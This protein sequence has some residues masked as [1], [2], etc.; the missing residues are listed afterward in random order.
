M[1]K[2]CMGDPLLIIQIK[3]SGIKDSLSYE[4]IP[5]QVLDRQ[6]RRLRTKEA[7]SVKVP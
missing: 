4:D 7:S 1:L 2:M 6:V 3:N 5:V